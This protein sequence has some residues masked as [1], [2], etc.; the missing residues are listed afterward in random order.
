MSLIKCKVQNT[1]LPFFIII[2]N[3]IIIIVVIVIVII[4]Y[5]YYYYYYYFNII[6]IIV[7]VIVIIIIIIIIIFSRYSLQRLSKYYATIFAC[8]YTVHFIW[9]MTFFSKEMFTL[10]GI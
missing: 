8:T 10:L 9:N 5:Y 6:I 7:I 1:V 4:Y 3:I 2:I